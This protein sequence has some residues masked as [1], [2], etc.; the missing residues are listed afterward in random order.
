MEVTKPDMI[1]GWNT[2]VVCDCVFV[3]VFCNTTEQSTPSRKMKFEI[4][5]IY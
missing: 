2:A 1:L 5:V 3:C 4:I